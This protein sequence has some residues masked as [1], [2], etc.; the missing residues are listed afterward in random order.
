M[1]LESRYG[2]LI[3]T[4]TSGWLLK[5][6]NGVLLIS[7]NNKLSIENCES[8]KRGCDLNELT[9]EKY[10]YPRIVPKGSVIGVFELQCRAKGFVVGFKTR[11]EM[12]SEYRYTLE[13]IKKAMDVS[14]NF[15]VN[16]TTENYEAKM[17]FLKSLNEKTEWDVEILVDELVYP[18]NMPKEGENR[19]PFQAKYDKNGKLQLKIRKK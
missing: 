15:A 18:A 14:H 10:G 3:K 12:L 8:I 11:E 5:D 19:P 4:N 7:K 1:K 17:E 13:D 2:K 6:E 16:Q 9:S